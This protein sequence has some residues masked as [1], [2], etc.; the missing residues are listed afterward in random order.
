M[1]TKITPY[2]ETETKPINIEI[3]EY[4]YLNAYKNM[5]KEDYAH[6]TDERKRSIIKDTLLT[7]DN[8]YLN[9]LLNMN[10]LDYT[11]EPEH[12]FNQLQEEIIHHKDEIE[13]V[14]GLNADWSLLNNRL[15]TKGIEAL[16]YAPNEPQIVLSF[17]EDLLT[18]AS[19]TE[20]IFK[21]VQG[22]SNPGEGIFIAA[23]R[24]LQEETNLLIEF[25]TPMKEHHELF[26]EYITHK[27]LLNQITSTISEEEKEKIITRAK[28]LKEKCMELSS[29]ASGASGA[30]GDCIFD[31]PQLCHIHI[32]HL[33]VRLDIHYNVEFKKIPNV[34]RPERKVNTYT[35]NFHL[36]SE[37][38]SKLKRMI[39]S[40]EYLNKLY[41]DGVKEVR[42]IK[43]KLVR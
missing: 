37:N 16:H 11:L 34:Y 27:E 8:I 9:K 3:P 10:I 13:K 2:D 12:W 14:D 7:V 20:N 1:N 31:G 33:A 38:K 24:E 4:R 26:T 5:I 18:V 25:E 15:W 23:Q 17:D 22:K 32:E 35:F 43:Y 36:D 42:R 6:V 21:N 28:F 29:S 39:Q 41:R 19:Y 40:P 30:S